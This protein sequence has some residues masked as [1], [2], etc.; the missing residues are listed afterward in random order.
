VTM[1]AR[2]SSRRPRCRLHR[3][4]NNNTIRL[5]AM[6]MSHLVVPLR[7]VSVVFWLVAI[8][9]NN[10]ETINMDMYIYLVRESEACVRE[11]SDHEVYDYEA[12]YVVDYNNN[13]ILM[14]LH[15]LYYYYYIDRFV[16][17]S[18]DV[19]DSTRRFSYPCVAS[20]SSTFSAFS[21]STIES[22][23]SSSLSAS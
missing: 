21:S 9:T 6:A 4:N 18:N 17:T 14:L 13:N 1:I 15:I 23:S 2:R 5:V 12:I 10:S 8:S 22:S 3:N 11:A 16:V 7:V 20:F 19:C